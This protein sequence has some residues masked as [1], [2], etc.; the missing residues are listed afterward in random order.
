MANRR[1]RV[2]SSEAGHQELRRHV[3]ANAVRPVTEAV[4]GDMRRYVP[5]LTGDLRGTI[6]TEYPTDLEG[7]VWFG[8]VDAGIDYH[9]H[10]EYGTEHMAAQPYA[11]P[12]LFKSR[13][14]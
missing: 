14:L 3:H 6:H 11:R 12:A 13:P 9:L 10:Q 2:V 4:A 7:R 8:D 5:V 1:V